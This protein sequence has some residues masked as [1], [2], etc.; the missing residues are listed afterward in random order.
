MDKI[1]EKIQKLLALAE[2][3]N[4]HEAFQAAK[5]ARNLMD[6]HSISKEDIE[7]AGKKE[8][9]EAESE[10][11]FK[12][13]NLW[14]SILHSSVARLN[15]CRGGIVTS[16]R[17]VKLLFQGFTADAV[18]AQ[19]TLDYLIDTCNRCAKESGARGRSEHY[20]FKVG[21][22]R[23]IAERIKSLIAEREASF[24][25]STGT[26][27]IPIKKAQVLNHFGDL[28]SA[29]SFK[30]RDPTMSEALAYMGGRIAG[31][32]TSLN[33]QV[34]GAETRKLQ[35]QVDDIKELVIHLLGSGW[36]YLIKN[37]NYLY[38]PVKQIFVKLD[39]Q[40]NTALLVR[41]IDSTDSIYIQDVEHIEQQLTLLGA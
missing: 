41:Q 6:K 27:L 40:A 10:F 37:N 21:F 9:L 7:Q 39:H 17:E 3:N 4:P 5:R 19:M 18:V 23:A 35:S 36:V 13:R 33:A 14:V 31:N 24:V 34:N 2:S 1:V 11:V 28:P 20:Q 25:S 12:Q 38:H 15:D 8:F 30:Y 26:N 22:A 29:R 16:D 32:N